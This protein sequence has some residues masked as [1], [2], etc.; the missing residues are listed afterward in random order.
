MA[1][2]TGRQVIFITLG[3]N[4][5][6]TIKIATDS[7]YTQNVEYILKKSIQ[8]FK[9]VYNAAPGSAY[10]YP[11]QT[12]AVV[13]FRNKQGAWSFELQDVDNGTHSNWRSGDQAAC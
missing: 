9:V 8:S 4:T 12:M 1:N 3:A 2:I 10:P 13:H 6:P 7:G 11:T 5:V